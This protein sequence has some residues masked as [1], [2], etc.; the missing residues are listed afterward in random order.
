M[1]VIASKFSLAVLAVLFLGLPLVAQ[2]SGSIQGLVVDAAGAVIPG[3]SVQAR[4]EAKG[5]V[6][7]ETKSGTDGLFLL[8]PLQPGTY[9]VSVRAQ[10]MKELQ[11]KGIFLDPYQKLDLGV[12]TTEVGGVNEV[13]SVE[14]QTPLVETATAD[15]S[16]VIDSKEVSETLLNGRDFQSLVKT[17]PGVVT[18]DASDF[19]LAFNN[20][21]A[22]NINGLRGSA[23]NVF[24]DG[25]INTDVGANDGQFTQLSMDAVGEFKLQTNNFA[26]E[27]G[28]NP[29]ILLAINTK[30]GGK[31]Y[32]GTLYEFNREDGFGATP[33]GQTSTGFLRFNQYG[34]NVGGPIPL[35]HAKDKLFFF[36]NYEGTRGLRPGNTQFAS[37]SIPGLGKGYTLPNPAVLTGD[38]TSQYAGGQLGH[39]T[40]QN[41]QI[42][43]PGTITY[44]PDG[45]I[46]DGTPICGTAA[47]P[48]N[49][50][51][52]GL[53]SAQA[54]AWVNYWQ[55]AYL[56]GAVPDPQTP[57]SVAGLFQKFF[58][59]FDE[60]YTLTKHQEVVRV[61]YNVNPKTSFFF[62]WVDDSQTENYHNLF[63]F[64]DYPILPEFRKKPGSSWSWNLVNV[65]TP[66]MTNEFIFSYNHLTQVV[67]IQ[68]GTPKSVFDR[69]ALG[70]TFNEIFPNSNVDNRAPVLNNCCN[71]TFTGGSF[72]PSWHSE[73]RQFTWTD[74]VTK[75]FGA[76]TFKTGVF[77]DYN[78]AGQQPVWNDTEFFSFT[79]GS[80]NPNDSGSYV[81]NVLLGNYSSVSQSNGVFFGA[82]R[83][84]Q[85]ELFGQDTW[86]V[87]RRLT[88]EY[89][90]R[91][92]YLGPTYTVQ[93]FFQNYFD[94]SLYDPAQ[95]VT[96]QTAVGSCPDGSG[97]GNTIGSI[98]PNTGNP[99]NGIVQENHGI[100]PGF[101]KH[102]YNNFGPRFGFA[103]DP[104]GS[105]KTAIRGGGGIFYERI[106]QNVNSFDGLGNPPLSYTPTAF[107]GNIDD[108]GPQVATGPRFP[109]GL[110]AFDK[111]GQIPTVYGYS[112]SVQR[113]LPWQT[114]L[115]VAYV[116][117]QGRHLQY[118]YNLEA[119][120][121]GSVLS[122]GGLPQPAFAPF[123]GYTNINFTK[124]DTNSSYNALQ[125]KATRRFHKDLTLTADY[126]YSKAMDIED[127]DN[128]N[129]CLAGNAGNGLTDPFNPKLDW[130]ASGFDRTHVF[131][132]NY[133]YTLPEFRNSG[134]FMRYVAGG[135][136]ISGITKF[137]S[138][139]PL[140]VKSNNGNPG[141]FVGVARPDLGSGDAYLDHSDKKSW[142]NPAVFIAPQPGTVGDIRRNAF[143]GPGINNWDISLFKNI[144]F[145][146]HVRLQLRLETFNTFNH[147]QP[148]TINT[149]FSSPGVG[150]PPSPGTVGNSGEVTGYRDAR[151][152]Q[153][154]V[155]L[156]F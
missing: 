85:L 50:I 150:L 16:S 10:G 94:P 40:F 27:Y 125:V 143:R 37:T 102:R 71:G 30:S 35:P 25:A 65:I 151:N 82:F 106:R 20:T 92:A 95:A 138:G 144:N 90:L 126:V 75:V 51:P 113:E 59:P 81:P 76:H 63:D 36:F 93:P 96:I 5:T 86:K 68:P 148:A 89:G 15:H 46:Q 29:G 115:E 107:N 146:E 114:G 141:N 69:T 135:W 84:H 155:K 124:Y 22:M 83:F 127:C 52:A 47:A 2:N 79:P 78:Q 77:F 72:R 153:L 55:Q 44:A 62:R 53:L 8:Q 18:N 123:K 110:N 129:G 26:A 19:R 41:G 122:L 128:G 140:D 108:L 48:C 31:Q 136:E 99:F 134:S 7:A 118:Q 132:F 9:T 116:G 121:V 56:P 103:Y 152:V 105:G 145:T 154:G 54:P 57:S 156:Y 74:N 97:T 32:H 14:A 64:A 34:G 13:I 104:T 61:D 117:N 23:N 17:L 43:V 111:A 58:V 42:F 130:A 91:W 80:S 109:V 12:V 137:W 147:T 6:V 131:N 33:F 1:K 101:A 100:P 11:R 4:D 87:N 66:T 142:L 39:S 112:L 133:V 60:T 139:V 70:F 120:P 49:I 67:D 38:F 21:D 98:C 45:Q 28:R 119:T 73:A 24:L 149:T 3:A 88:L